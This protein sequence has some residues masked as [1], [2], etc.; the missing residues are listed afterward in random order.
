MQETEIRRDEKGR[1]LADDGYPTAGLASITEA[2]A[3]SGL[4]RSKIYNM[5]G[6]GELETRRFGKSRRITWASMRATFLA[7][8][9]SQ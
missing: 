9:V 7:S 1:V 6:T 4:S 2:V 3:V 5:I 8:E